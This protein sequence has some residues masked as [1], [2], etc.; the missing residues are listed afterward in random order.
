MKSVDLANNLASASGHGGGVAW[1]LCAVM[2]EL[3]AVDRNQEDCLSELNTV[4]SALTPA[5]LR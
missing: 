4:E 2:G 1:L 5:Q 3:A